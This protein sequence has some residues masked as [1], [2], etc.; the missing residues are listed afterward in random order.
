MARRAALLQICSNPSGISETYKETPA[1]LVALDSL[2]KQLVGREREKI[3]IWSFYTASVAAIARRYVR[4][5]VV[6]YDGSVSDVGKRGDAVRRFQEDD[7]T[8]VF[9]AN[10]AAAG[11]GLT[12]H[13]ARVAIYESLSN[14]TAHYLQSLD[15]I[16]RRG[17]ERDVEYVVLLCDGT[18]EVSEYERLVQKEQAAQDLLGDNV[19]APLTPG[20]VPGGR[21]HGRRAAEHGRKLVSDRA[22]GHAAIPSRSHEVR[23][24]LLETIADAA[25]YRLKSR[26][27]DGK[28]PDVLRLH[29]NRTGLFLGEAKHTEGPTE[30]CSVDRLRVYLDWLVPLCRQNVGSLL[31][32]AHPRGLGR[33]WRDRVGWL[34]QDAQIEGFVESKAVTSNT[35][36]TFCRVRNRRLTLRPTTGHSEDKAHSLHLGV[37]ARQTAQP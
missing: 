11:A 36:V 1:K 13:R 35:T 3:V 21:P 10:P 16:H 20:H 29:V 7:E 17:Q 31:A 27:P 4:Y 32:I 19:E 23:R 24:V 25:G 18:L 37:P 2:V 9:V 33:A 12:L 15:R 34:L 28:R 8:M 5:G 26:F 6:R 22:S 14:Q 30:S